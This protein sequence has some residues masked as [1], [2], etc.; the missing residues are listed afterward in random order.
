MNSGLLEK[1]GVK[2]GL[3]LILTQTEVKATAEET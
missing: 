2:M 1:R 3:D